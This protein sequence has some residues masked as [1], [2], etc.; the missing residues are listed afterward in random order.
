MNIAKTCVKAKEST[1]LCAWPT[2]KQAMW[3]RV[4]ISRVGLGKTGLEVLLSLEPLL[5]E[6]ADTEDDATRRLRADDVSP[7]TAT[8]T[9]S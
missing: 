2:S 5:E 1:F 3:R 9:C 8:C 6:A 7:G 4:L